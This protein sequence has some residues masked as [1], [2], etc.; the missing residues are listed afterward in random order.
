MD[1]NRPR[2]AFLE[3]M[4]VFFATA[5]AASR[6]NSRGATCRLGCAIGWPGSTAAG[7]MTSAA[8]PQADAWGWRI[9]ARSFWTGS[10][11]RSRRW[12]EVPPPCYPE[13]S[14]GPGDHAIR[15]R[16]HP[17]GVPAPAGVVESELGHL[18]EPVRNPPVLDYLSV[19]ESADV[20]DGNRKRF[21]RRRPP[22]EPFAVC[23]APR[24]PRPDLISV[25]DHVLDS[26]TERREGVAKVADRSL[27]LLEGRGKIELVFGVAG[28]E[29]R[30]PRPACCP[31]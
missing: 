27:E 1:N 4:Q 18:V 15:P 7:C 9:R 17:S 31:C 30:R 12:R 25:R 28:E 23:P 26:Q 22:H 11:R 16:S 29:S 24:H 10:P 5:P 3:E 13:R 19:L 2:V 21:A 8:Q 14:T 6:A 20:N